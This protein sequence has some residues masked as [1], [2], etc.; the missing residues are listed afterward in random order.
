MANRLITAQ[1]LGRFLKD[2]PRLRA[3]DLTVEM[4]TKWKLSLRNRGYSPESINHYLSAV[5]AIY[6]FA[7]KTGSKDYEISGSFI[8]QKTKKYKEAELR[9]VNPLV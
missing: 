9:I 1:Q 7:S 4:F 2:F 8:A 3:V 6:S 5:R